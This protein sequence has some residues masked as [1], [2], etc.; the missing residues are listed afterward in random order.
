VAVMQWQRLSAEPLADD[1]IGDV[2][3]LN[4]QHNTREQ[5]RV[6]VADALTRHGRS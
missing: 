5:I 3:V 4:T 6:R 2:V 1:E